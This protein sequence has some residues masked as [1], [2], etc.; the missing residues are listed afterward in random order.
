M[1]KSNSDKII[2]LMKMR[3]EIDAACIAEELGISKEGARQQLLKLSEE[4][5]VHGVCKKS[6]VGRPFTFYSLSQ[7]GLAKFPD[8]HADITVQLLQSIKS[9]LGENAL[10]L[11][12]TDRE[13][14]S[15]LRYEEKLKIGRASCREREKMK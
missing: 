13:K 3:G 5:L 9:L 4:G 14:S 7:T 1:K 10:D 2:M 11:L 15:Y 6:G 8:N 12:I